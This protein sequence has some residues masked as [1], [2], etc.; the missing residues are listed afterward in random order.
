MRM[1]REAREGLIRAWLEILH[2]R[3]PEV[4]WVPIDSTNSPEDH[5]STDAPASSVPVTA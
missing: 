3:H 5:P 1:P 4:T 2:E